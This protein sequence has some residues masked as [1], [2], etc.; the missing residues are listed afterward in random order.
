MPH[1]L[2]PT[3]TL[4]LSAEMINLTLA[5]SYHP[6]LIAITLGVATC[7]I[8]MTLCATQMHPF[9][10]FVITGTV[11]FV[12]YTQRKEY[13]FNANNM[14]C[15][16]FLSL[17][18]NSERHLHVSSESRQTAILLTCNVIWGLIAVL[19]LVQWEK[20]FTLC[21]Y[22][23][24]SN[25]ALSTVMFVVHSFLYYEPEND[26]FLILR[27]FDFVVLSVVWMYMFHA[28][29]L[30]TTDVFDCVPCLLRFA[31]VLFVT[32]LMTFF[33]SALCCMVMFAMQ[34]AGYGFEEG[35]LKSDDHLSDASLEYGDLHH[36]SSVNIDEGVAQS[37]SGTPPPSSFSIMEE[38]MLIPISQ[39]RDTGRE[40]DD[41]G[42]RMKKKEQKKRSSSSTSTSSSARDMVSTAA[43]HAATHVP[44]EDETRRAFAEALRATKARGMLMP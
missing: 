36:M 23:P 39:Q 22:I 40:R 9:H 14:A 27:A 41:S 18:F 1:Y 33:F 20:R 11:L 13:I 26:F 17:V 32:P 24:V 15:F 31:P 5:R 16:I 30:S 29:R 35:V 37:P 42:S 25:T 2:N 43:T 44:D 8:V 3:S 12:D 34:R 10:A 19:T 7:T 4:N 28:H 6:V 21:H 38:Q